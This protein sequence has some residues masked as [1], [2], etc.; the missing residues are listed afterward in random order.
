MAACV[1]LFF[2]TIGC[3]APK[4]DTANK[5]VAKP[6]MAAIK[7][8]IQAI[9]KDWEVAD[10]TRNVEVFAAFY[11]DD[12]ISIQPYKPDMAVGKAAIRKNIEEYMSKKSKGET[13]TFE[14][15]EVFGDGNVITEIGKTTTKDVN[16]KVK[17]TNKF[18]CIWEKR[19]GKYVSIRDIF[20][21]DAPQ[22][23]AATK[24]IHVFDMPNGVT[25][26]QW[27]SEVKELNAVIAG[28]GYPN[29][30]YTFYKTSDNSV[31][32][33]RYYFE[34]VWPAGDGYKKIHEHPKFLE[35]SKKM[36]PLFAKIKAVEM[37]RKLEK[38]N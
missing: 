33:N 28:I 32:N 26:A 11:A 5:A 23:A 19:N 9:E 3:N 17:S 37:Y 2:T 15:M 27:A 4:S 22:P 1:A 10:N 30:G 38:V 29:A 34:G 31:K 12:A 13:N 25:E 7:A 24:S 35:A 21:D 16:G 6:D 36:D 20:S 18:M 8:E 14:T